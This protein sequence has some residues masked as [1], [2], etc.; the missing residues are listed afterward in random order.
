MTQHSKDGI[1]AADRRHEMLYSECSILLIQISTSSS[2]T[3]A[4][5]QTDVE[6]E[7]NCPDILHRYF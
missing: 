5:M 1:P 3:E 4:Q 2:Y 6:T 7:E